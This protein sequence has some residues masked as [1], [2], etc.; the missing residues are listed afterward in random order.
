M[1]REY[2]EF[3]VKINILVAKAQKKPEEGWVRKDGNPWPGSNM[4]D[5]PGMIQIN[6]KGL[7]GIQ[8]PLYVGTGCVFNRQALYGFDPLSDKRPKM[9]S[10]CW[11]S[12][13][14]CC[15]SDSES[16]SDDDIDQEL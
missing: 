2:E 4:D 16:S 8:G 15:S 10:C 5:H 1:K 14:S 7:D 12:S 3:N 9:K 11:P 6:M 13:C